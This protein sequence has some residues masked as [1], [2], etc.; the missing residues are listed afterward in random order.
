ML[1]SPPNPKVVA[2]IDGVVTSAYLG[3]MLFNFFY[4]NRSSDCVINPYSSYYGRAY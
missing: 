2:T 4:R 1:V 3:S